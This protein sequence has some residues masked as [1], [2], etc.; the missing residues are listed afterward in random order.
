MIIGTTATFMDCFVCEPVITKFTEFTIGRSR[1]PKAT[2][3]L[4][5]FRFVEFDFGFGLA[6]RVENSA[7]SLLTGFID[8][9]NSPLFSELGWFCHGGVYSADKEEKILHR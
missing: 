9:A 6:A 8:P 4:F 2:L 1:R 7:A 5:D 3:N